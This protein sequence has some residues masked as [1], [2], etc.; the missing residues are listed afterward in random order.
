[1]VT[2]FKLIKQ[3]EMVNVG[4][5]EWK[6]ADEYYIIIGNYKI[7]YKTKFIKMTTI[8]KNGNR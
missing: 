6:L 8:L 4:F 2:I 3:R 1:M 5:L 7:K